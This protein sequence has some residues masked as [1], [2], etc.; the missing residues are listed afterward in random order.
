[1]VKAEGYG[2]HSRIYEHRFMVASVRCLSVDLQ[3]R[4]FHS[5]PPKVLKL[6]L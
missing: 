6:K 1:M 5:T 4:G 3:G 2:C